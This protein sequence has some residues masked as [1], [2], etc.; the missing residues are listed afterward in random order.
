[1]R[2]LIEVADG[3]S[4]ATSAIMSTTSTVLARDGAALL[5]DP[6][7]LPSELEGLADV[8]DARALNVVGGFAT[9]AHHDHL[10][11]HERFG[12]APRWASAATAALARDER[13]AL[14]EF[15]GAEFPRPLAD[16]M[17]RVE[18]V[19][20]VIPADSV[21]SGFAPEL[22]VHDGHAPGHTAVWLPDQRVLIAGDM[23][24]DLELPLPFWPDDLDSYVAALDLL[25]PYAA[26]AAIVIPG[27]GTPGGDAVA[28]LDADR[29]YLDDVVAGRVPADP[30]M[31]H[32][33]MDEEYEHLKRLVAGS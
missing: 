21:P 28:R 11:W 6:S 26:R 15:L 7:W 5:I 27:H 4:V 16:L 30:R 20:A 32:P 25:A 9:H 18:G 29:R 8:L 23:L 19:D 1:M 3:V 13:A 22:V 33:G 10:L 31:A 2:E 12:A 17:G 14:L 24:S